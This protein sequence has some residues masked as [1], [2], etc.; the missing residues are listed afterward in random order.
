MVF[1]FC[2]FLSLLFSVSGLSDMSSRISL[3]FAL[4]LFFS[5]S[6][7]VHEQSAGDSRNREASGSGGRVVIPAPLLV[8]LTGGDRFLAANSEAVRFSVT[9]WEG[10]VGDTEYMARSQF[11]VSRLNPCH[12]DNYYMANGLLAWGGA[13]ATGNAVLK[14]AMACRYWDGL[15]AFFYGV[16]KYF[17]D[18]DL[19]S[20]AD[21]IRV[22][23]AR[24]PE[25]SSV[26]LK[27]AVMI[28][29]ESFSSV[30]L[31]LGYLKSQRDG[32]KDLRLR[33][34]LE[35]RIVRLEGLVS[36]RQAQRKYELKYGALN[37]LEDL[38]S[39]GYLSS[40][41]VD[42]LGLGYVFVGGEIDLRR[43]R[44]P[45]LEEVL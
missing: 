5:F 37:S 26:L 16:N 44:V 3:Y 30:D 28:E 22:S 24:W 19:S 21:A 8:V 45:G 13:V 43:L 38:V 4:L 10:S 11:E 14:R 6:W 42:P 12:E 1:H 7:I 40:I 32:A 33:G 41:P 15:P 35:K 20:A 18:K 25:N 27:F 34:M 9:A 39:K 17:F 31:T 2:F 23:A 36:L 29:A